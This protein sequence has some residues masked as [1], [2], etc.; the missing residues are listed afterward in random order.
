M[1]KRLFALTALCL[2][3]SVTA[4][5]STPPPAPS[6]PQLTYAH[7][8]PIRLDVNAIKIMPAYTPPMRA[9]NVEHLFPAPPM[10]AAKNWGTSRLS[11][12]DISAS[13]ATA[14]FVI[15]DAGVIEEKLP[16]TGGI[17]GYFTVDQGARY[18][19]TLKARLEIIDAQGTRIAFAEATAFRD[20]TIPENA[21]VNKREDY[22]FR[23]TEDLLKDF[24]REMEAAIQTHLSRFRVA[25]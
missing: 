23:L 12:A 6:Q 22:W 1:Q 4:A 15:L 10:R 24:N 25:P 7:K 9:P 2:S 8:A 16:T 13:G 5:C 3:L 19:A 14:R 18:T 20:Q 21:S 11:A 17:G